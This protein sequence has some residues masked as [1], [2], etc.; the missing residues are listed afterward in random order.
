MRYLL[1]IALCVMPS[2]CATVADGTLESTE[3][4]TFVSSPSGAAIKSPGR[5]FCYTPCRQTV[6]RRLIP[7]LYAEL[8][9]YDIVPVDTSSEF[10]ALVLGNAIAGGL[11]GLGID[12]LTGRASR[13][14]DVVKIDFGLPATGSA[15]SGIE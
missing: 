14:D 7:Q 11:P 13:V 3:T 8:P 6:P 10:N 5:T 9:G 1:V 12:I 4:I 15:P 2:A